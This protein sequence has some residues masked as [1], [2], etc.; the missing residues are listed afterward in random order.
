MEKAK[1]KAKTRQSQ[2]FAYLVNTKTITPSINCY[3]ENIGIS[4]KI[5]KI[6]ML[7]MKHVECLFI[8]EVE[9]VHLKLFYHHLQCIYLS[10]SLKL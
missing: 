2:W 1:E 3:T 6:T 7:L 5:E 8:V 9:L 10:N 4:L